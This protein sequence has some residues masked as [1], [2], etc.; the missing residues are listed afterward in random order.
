MQ[1]ICETCGA[2]FS[3][4]PSALIHDPPRFCSP[5]CFYKWLKGSERA[6]RVN[7]KCQTCGKEMRVLKSRYDAG[8]G[9]FCSRECVNTG[10]ISPQRKERVA[11]TCKYCGKTF[12]R[13]QCQIDSGRGIFCSRSCVA[14]HTNR[15]A[16]TESPT[17][18]EE[19]LIAELE[20]RDIEYEFQY[21]LGKWVLDFAFPQ[22]HIA[23]EADGVYWHSLPKAVEKDKRKEADLRSR[24]WK[25]LRFDGDMIRDSVSDCV[26]RVTDCLFA[27]R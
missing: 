10:R 17:S 11:C 19:A 20:Q 15:T 16:Y 27:L 24:G 8:Q 26:D 6:P 4:P 18:I 5:D 23:V 14:A 21:S 1:F 2:D 12:Y 25:L 3:R 22:Q 13:L 7:V 9:R